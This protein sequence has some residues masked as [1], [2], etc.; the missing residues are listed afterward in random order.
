MKTSYI[1]VNP[2]WCTTI[3]GKLFRWVACDNGVQVSKYNDYLD[4]KYNEDTRCSPPQQISFPE[5]Q[6]R[7]NSKPHE[8]GIWMKALACDDAQPRETDIFGPETE[9]IQTHAHRS[10]SFYS[11]Y[12]FVKLDAAQTTHAIIYDGCSEYPEEV[13]YLELAM[14]HS[15]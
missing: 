4:G 7:R 9:L 15:Q 3:R 8:A 14:I 5:N 11:T 2:W 10:K 13:K 12:T 1:K 6:S